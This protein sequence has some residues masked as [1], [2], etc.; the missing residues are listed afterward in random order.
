M[1]HPS[2]ELIL[3]QYQVIGEVWTP[4]PARAWVVLRPQTQTNHL[5]YHLGPF[6]HVD[7]RRRLAEWVDAVARAR[8]S[9][10]LDIESFTLGHAR[11][12]WLVAPYTGNHHDLVRLPEVVEKRGGQL[13][14]FEVERAV[15][16]LLDALDAAHEAGLAH[17]P[18]APEEVLVDRR[19]RLT[20]ELFALRRRLDGLRA[21]NAELRRDEVRSIVELGY[22][23]LTGIDAASPPIPAGRLIR[24]IP[25]G[26]DSWFAAGLDPTRGFDSPLAAAAALPSSIG[27]DTAETTDTGMRAV[28]GR[29]RA[30]LR[31][32]ASEPAPNGAEP[33]ASEVSRAT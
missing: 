25:R 7:E 18:I 33:D 1:S 21:S 31:D 5:V 20:L 30:S 9:H 29:L 16:Q 14:S 22:K 27:A 4:A 23:L 13:P 2:G 15:G 8:E 11:D 3:D 19:G 17:G 28:L 10:L 12:A 6:D 32:R 24:R 26:W